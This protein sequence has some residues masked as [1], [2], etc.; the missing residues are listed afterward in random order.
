MVINDVKLNLRNMYVTGWRT[1]SVGR[2]EWQS[3]VKEE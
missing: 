1:R 3:V 2:T